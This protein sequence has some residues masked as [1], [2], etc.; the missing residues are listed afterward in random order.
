[1]LTA[2]APS[3]PAAG[4]NKGKIENDP[5]SDGSLKQIKMRQET[6]GDF[7]MQAAD[8]DWYERDRQTKRPK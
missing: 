3:H 2:P 7:C 5:S 1:L 8:S 6:L 4:T